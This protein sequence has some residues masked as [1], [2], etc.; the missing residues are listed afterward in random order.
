M[1]TPTN[2][3]SWRD[4]VER[5]VN[6]IS[7]TPRHYVGLLA[8]VGLLAAPVWLGTLTMLNMITAF[9]FIM[10]VISWDF[11]SGYTDQV[12]FGHT[13]FFAIGGY[14]S[15]ILNLE[16]G[17][18]PLVGIVAGILLTSVAGILYA[19][20][21]LRIE[22]HYLALFTLMPP[23]ILGQLFIMF[24]DIFGGTRGLPTPEPLL[25]VGDFA[26]T[27]FWNYYL[28]LGAL[29]LIF[30]VAF[31]ITRSDTG[32]IFKAIREDKVVVAA[33]GLDPVKFKIFA[34]VFSAALAGFAGAMFAHSPVGSATPGQ[35]L[36]LTII[37]D[38]L[39]ASILGGVGTI[40]GPAVGGFLFWWVR[41]ISGNIEWMVPVVDVPFSRIDLLVFYIVTLGILLFIP[42]G[43]V[44]VF[45]ELGQTV[46]NRLRAMLG[47]SPGD[48]S[49]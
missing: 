26:T 29:L 40:V 37:I 24:S 36:A 33:S 3:T 5:I 46:W 11:V 30:L 49:G 12:S 1:A 23:L 19:V 7:L 9:Y 43:I 28:A 35:L 8:V 48:T 45:I 2:L 21:A 4:T 20:P 17:L 44:P 22:G 31:A 16:L 27:A 10:F 15:V 13:F 34:M 47:R 41:Q 32:K 42:R 14:T 18:P 39:L 6:S 25:Q 38:I